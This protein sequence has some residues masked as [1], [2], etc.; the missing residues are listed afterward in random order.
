MSAIAPTRR[1][2]ASRTPMMRYF[3]SRR[4]LFRRGLVDLDQRQPWQR[5]RKEADQPTARRMIMKLF[6]SLATAILVT[7][8]ALLS[9][10]AQAGPMPTNAAAMKSMVDKSTTEVRY[11]GG[12]GRVG[13]GG[14]GRVGRVGYAGVGRGVGYRRVGYGVAAGAIVGG[15]VARRAYYGGDVGYSGYSDDSYGFAPEPQYDYA[16]EPQYGYRG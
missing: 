8:S 4:R 5:R 2:I 7:T 15:A 3:W 10:G 16:A 1:A 11:R 13:Y 14:V 12:V 6:S 9:A